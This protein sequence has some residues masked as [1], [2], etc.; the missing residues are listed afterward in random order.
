MEATADRPAGIRVLNPPWVQGTVDVYFTADDGTRLGCDVRAQAAA[1]TAWPFAVWT[2]L[3]NT[4]VTVSLPD[5]TQVPAGSRV[6]LVDVASGKRHYARTM[7]GLTYNSREGGE[8]KFVLEIS[9]ETG[10]QLA[11]SAASAQ[12]T[13]VGVE[14]TYALS[15]RATVAA[16]VR[17]VAGREVATITTGSDVEAGRNSVVWNLQSAS[18]TKVPG[19]RYII[20]L[21]AV[22]DDGQRASAIQSVSVTR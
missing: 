20:E 13:G 22:T 2:D 10:G 6:T 21:N 17:N 9:P 8:R 18:G 7:A 1:T 19:G 5:L 4:P 16:T 11:I 3:Q 14:I 12:Q 15:A